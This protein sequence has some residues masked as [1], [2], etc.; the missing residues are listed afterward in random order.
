M[1]V[2]IE[3]RLLTRPASVLLEVLKKIDEQGHFD[4][5]VPWDWIKWEEVEFVDDDDYA[6]FIHEEVPEAI[7]GVAK[8]I[9]AKA[10]VYHKKDDVPGA[11]Y[12]V[13]IYWKGKRYTLHVDYSPGDLEKGMFTLYIVGGEKGWYEPP[14]YY[15]R[16]PWL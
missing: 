16:V 11:E 8:K 2:K 14:V 7:V 9:G 10:Y 6:K 1:S 13:Q 15:H 12:I 5:N 4:T 3:P